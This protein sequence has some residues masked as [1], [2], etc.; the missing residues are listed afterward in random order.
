MDNEL[1]CDVNEFEF[2]WD[3]YAHFLKNTLGK[4]MNPFMAPAVI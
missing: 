4:G 1:D 2:Q 3:Y